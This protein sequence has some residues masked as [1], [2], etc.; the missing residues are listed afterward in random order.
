MSYDIMVSVRKI[1]WNK[2][3]LEPCLNEKIKERT[4]LQDEIKFP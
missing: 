2:N 4:L 3:Q 1:G